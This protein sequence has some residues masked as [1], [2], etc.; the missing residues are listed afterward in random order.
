MA[1]GISENLVCITPILRY[2]MGAT[3]YGFT[4]KTPQGQNQPSQ[5]AQ[6]AAPEPSQEADLAEVIPPRD[7]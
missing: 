5:T 7:K 4:K 3:P 2:S 6:E 1:A